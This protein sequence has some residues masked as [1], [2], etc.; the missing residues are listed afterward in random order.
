MLGWTPVS[1]ETAYTAER[2]LRL[3][4]RAAAPRGTARRATPPSVPC[5][6]GLLRGRAATA[7]AWTSPGPYRLHWLIF[8]NSGYWGGE[9][10]RHSRAPHHVAGEP[11]WSSSRMRRRRRP[12]LA[13]L[14]GRR[15]GGR[16][17]VG[18][19][20]GPELAQPVRF[21]PAHGGTEGLTC[22]FE[23]DGS[24][25]ARSPGAGAVPDR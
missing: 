25:A 18:H 12:R 24:G 21:G 20:H 4:A 16:G 19:V 8:E 6:A 1:H 2:G 22:R 7:S 9:Q 15:A 17:P 13:P 3:A 14:R 5:S 11:V 23:A 10:A